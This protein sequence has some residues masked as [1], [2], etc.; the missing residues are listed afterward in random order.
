MSKISPPT[1]R[2]QR[3]GF[4]TC[5]DRHTIIEVQ[6]DK[7][8][9]LESLLESLLLVIKDMVYTE[10]LELRA[11]LLRTGNSDDLAFGMREG[12]LRGDLPRVRTSTVSRYVLRLT[13]PT[14][15]AAPDTQTTSP[16]FSRPTSNMP[17]F[18]STGF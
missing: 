6:V 17:C 4:L 12:D 14:E 16:S 13:R 10:L 9:L 2:C 7:A 3:R 1:V 11:L 8:T 5:W 15:P 18:V